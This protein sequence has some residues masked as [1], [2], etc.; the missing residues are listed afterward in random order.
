M[1]ST[2]LALGWVIG[3]LLGED[4]IKLGSSLGES[5]C[6]PGKWSGAQRILGE[7]KQNVPSPEAKARIGRGQETEGIV[8]WVTVAERARVQDP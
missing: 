8:C 1:G 3:R 5:S 7:K 6:K 4:D 2:D